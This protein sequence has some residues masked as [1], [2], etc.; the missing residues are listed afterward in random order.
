MIM[1]PSS[2]RASSTA[3]L[4]CDARLCIGKVQPPRLLDFLEC[5]LCVN[6]RWGCDSSC[7][8]LPGRAQPPAQP[9]RT[10]HC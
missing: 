3:L 2:T 7:V 8:L 1:F 5:I 10:T 4:V 6:I 9:P